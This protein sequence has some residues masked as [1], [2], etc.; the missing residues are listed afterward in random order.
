MYL[1]IAFVSCQ[2]TGRRVNAPAAK[3]V[4]NSGA[5]MNKTAIMMPMIVPTKV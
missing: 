3:P 2:N 1:L 5:K 4:K